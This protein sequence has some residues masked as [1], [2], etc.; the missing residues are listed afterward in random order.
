MELI[1]GG[2]GQG[3]LRY[4]LASSGL[5]EAAVTYDP[6]VPRPIFAGLET[7]L[8]TH[9]DPMPALEALIAACPEVRILCAEVGSGVVPMDKGE[10]VWRER[11]GRTCCHL[12]EAACKVTRLYCGIPSVIKGE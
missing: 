9:D 7:W 10:R 6:T 5:D 4:A 1:I 3:K 11:V 8:K 12:A 2:I